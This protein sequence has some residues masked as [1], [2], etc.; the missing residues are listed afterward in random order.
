MNHAMKIHHL[1]CG[2]LRPRYP[3]V[4]AI[5]YCLLIETDEGLMLVDTGF[6]TEDYRHPGLKLRFFLWMMGSPRAP[7]ETALQQVAEMGFDP[8]D[9]RHI[10]QTHLH[11]DH[12]GGLRDFPEAQVHV[13]QTEYEAA[14]A[15]SSLMDFAYIPAHW[16]HD[17]QWVFHQRPDREWFGFNAISIYAGRFTEILMIPLP[18]HTRG[19]CGVAVRSGERWLLHCGDA[20]SPF[21]HASDLHNRDRS[22]YAL[23][24]LPTR[25]ATAVLG[26]HVE[27]LR[28]LAASHGEVVE[29]ISSHDIFS[30]EER[31]SAEAD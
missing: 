26:P 28:A 4:H 25:F 27:R 19:H 11:I 13:H 10:I 29:L 5:V 6:G 31:S 12:A 22:G 18:G 3:R 24:F 8:E 14:I 17:P 16:A 15:P 20:A 1:N 23:D 9:V 7:A 2:T 30:F 21:H